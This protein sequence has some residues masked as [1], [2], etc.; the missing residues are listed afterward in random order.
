MRRFPPTFANI[1]RYSLSGYGLNTFEDVFGRP[2]E[3]RTYD[4]IT[5]VQIQ[6]S[7]QDF[8]KEPERT[9]SSA[10]V[11]MSVAADR[12]AFYMNFSDPSNRLKTGETF[13][14]RNIT[15]IEFIFMY[16]FNHPNDQLTA[17]LQSEVKRLASAVVQ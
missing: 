10:L 11:D 17:Q 9:M 15:D 1:E 4:K 5:E 14:I 2:A 6:A 16:S 13:P 12:W 3:Q 7:R 8:L